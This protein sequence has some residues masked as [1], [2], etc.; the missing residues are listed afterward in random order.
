[1]EFAAYAF[2]VAL[3]FFNKN[4]S[5][6]GEPRR[7]VAVRGTTVGPAF[8]RKGSISEFSSNKGEIQA[9]VTSGCYLLVE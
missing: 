1:M 4:A 3:L 8:V 9:Y 6:R 2:L 7:G 5:V